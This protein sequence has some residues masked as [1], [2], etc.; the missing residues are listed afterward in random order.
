MPWIF[1]LAKWAHVGA[2]SVALTV[3]P[4]AMV[5]QKGGGAHRLWGR[6]YFWAMAAVFVSALLMSFYR[7]V[8][9]LIGV[10]VLSFYSTLS[11]YQVLDRKRAGQS[12]ARR[13]D[14]SGAAVALAMGGGLVLW[15]VAALLGGEGG[16][17]EALGIV[18]GGITCKSALEDI[19]RFRSPP[20]D[21]RFWWYFHMERMLGSYI[22]LTTALLVQV[23]GPRLLDAGMDPSLI[24]TVWIAPS[25]LMGPGVAYWIGYYRRRFS[26]LGGRQA[27]AV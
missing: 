8:L 10:A 18:F 24:W 15:S 7:P 5:T 20:E 13:R 16:T 11:G 26:S 3:G 27:A 23:V 14:W 17:F 1:E 21:R 9:F 4:L 6:I 25:V 12:L 19:W 22:G 2:A